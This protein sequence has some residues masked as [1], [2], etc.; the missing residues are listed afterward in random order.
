MLSKG[1]AASI[2]ERTETHVVFRYRPPFTCGEQVLIL[3]GSIFTFGLALLYV[4]FRIW[5]RQEVRLI[6]RP[7]AGDARACW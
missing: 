5:F 1:G 6:A 2:E 3:F 4:A 7:A